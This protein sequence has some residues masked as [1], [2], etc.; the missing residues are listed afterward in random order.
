MDIKK[1]K[2]FVDFYADWCGPCKMMAPIVDELAETLDDVKVIKINVDNEPD[3]ALEY[4]VRN[5]PCFLYLEDGEVISKA[6]G[7]KRIEDLKSM[8]K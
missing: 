4:S 1:G 5:I 2:V 3:L 7:T 8:V 6:I